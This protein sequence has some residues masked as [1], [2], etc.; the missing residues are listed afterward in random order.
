MK[1]RQPSTAWKKM[2]AAGN[3]N[4][5][6]YEDVTAKLVRDIPC[7]WPC[8]HCVMRIAREIAALE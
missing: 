4:R 8:H 6:D 1:K 5:H 2:A 3:V 7:N